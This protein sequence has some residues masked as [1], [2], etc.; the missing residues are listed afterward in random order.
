M[1]I[2]LKRGRGEKITLGVSVVPLQQ[3]KKTTGVVLA[4]NDITSSKQSQDT[5][6]RIDRLAN[7]GTLAAGMAHEIKNALV[8][9]KTFIDLLLEKNKDTE[10]VQV[11]GRELGR[12]DAI[13]SRMLKFAGPDRPVIHPVS[14]HEILDHSLRLVRTRQ[15]DK[16]ISLN[17]S[18]QADPDLVRGDDYQLQQAFVNLLLNALEAMGPHGTLTVSTETMSADTAG[19]SSKESGSRR[20]HITI[21]DSGEG[22]APEHLDRVFDPFFTTKSEGTGLGL[23]ITRR[24]IE[25]HQGTVT[26]NSRPRKGTTFRIILPAHAPAARGIVMVRDCLTLAAL[27]AHEQAFPYAGNRERY[28]LRRRSRTGAGTELRVQQNH[29]SPA[30]PDREVLSELHLAPRPAAQ[31][32]P[33]G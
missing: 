8:A 19:K 26:V 15:Q 4:I 30:P 1:E 5:L 29:Q 22:I 24:I 6:W 28:S 21:A 32:L 16:L 9:G 17:Q 3:D 33:G 2:E 18:F 7:L 14:V 27:P 10:L 23:P 25:D 13:V 31:G 11:V 20:V 12:I